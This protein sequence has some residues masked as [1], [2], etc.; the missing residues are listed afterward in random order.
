M[1]NISLVVLHIS[2]EDRGTD[3]GEGALRSPQVEGA[4]PDISPA[5]DAPS[6]NERHHVEALN[7]ASGWPRRGGA[8]GSRTGGASTGR[9]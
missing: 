4:D 2:A 8:I 3:L 1:P 9:A 7:S 6:L 5:I